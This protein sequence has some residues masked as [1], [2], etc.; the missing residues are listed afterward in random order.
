MHRAVL[1]WVEQ[2]LSFWN[3][4]ASFWNVPADHKLR[5]LEFGSLD[6][7]G[8]VRSILQP[9]ASDYVG[10]DPNYGR[11]VDIVADASVFRDVQPFDVVVCCEVFE[12]TP[13]WRLIINNAHLNLVKGGLFIA[14]M[15]GE[16]RNPHSAIDE[17]PIRPWE[18]YANVSASELEPNMAIFEKYEINVFEQDTRVRATK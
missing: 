11:G 6:I 15:A 9:M 5:V 16:G 18:Y 8:S 4:P 10:I 14:T 13:K 1:D 3:V 2:S 17:N 7:N 12:H